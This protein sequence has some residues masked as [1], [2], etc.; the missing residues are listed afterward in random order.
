M[1]FIKKRPL[2][3]LFL[4]GLIVRLSMIYYDYSWDVN[5]HM[6]WA[7]DLMMRGPINFYET[8]SSNVFAYPTPNYPP[9][10]IYIFVVM[11]GLNPLIHRLYWWLNITIPLIP[12]KLIFFLEKT[13]FLAGLM[14]IPAILADLGVAL[15]VFFFAKKIIPKNK[16]GQIIATSFILFNPAF[17]FNSALWGQI[18]SVPI[19]FVLLSSYFLLYSKKDFLSAV[20]FLAA[21]L[22]KPTVI[23]FLPVYGVLFIKKCG[24]KKTVIN[25]LLM[26]ILFHLSFFPF[27]KGKNIFLYPYQVYWEKILAAQS[28]SFVTNGAFNPWVLITKMKGVKDTAVF[29]LGVPYRAFG[30]VITGILGLFA[31]LPIIKGKKTPEDFFTAMFLV[32]FAAFLF[33]TKMHER[34]SLLPLVFL[35]L[36]SL[37][38][39]KLSGWFVFL[40]IISFI[41]HYHSWAVPWCEPLFKIVDNLFFISLVSLINTIVFLYLF[42]TLLFNKRAKIIDKP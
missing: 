24:F 27:I 13:V 14:K 21:L 22:I 32:A 38:R 39:K 16:K 12:S 36:L 10:A 23:I 30:Y 40:S 35:L 15:M 34:Y 31:I 33:L 20:L 26:T 5:N 25:L 29:F 41:N 19:F 11:K 28:L 37:K 42:K 3:I 2:F 6:V 7:K 4:L 8:I 18:D 17:I 9:L 1:K